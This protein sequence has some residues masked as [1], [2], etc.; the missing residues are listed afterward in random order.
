MNTDRRTA[1]AALTAAGLLWGTTVPLSKVA[2]EWLPPGWLALVR[3][4]VAAA[5]LLGVARF[6]VRAACRP[7]VLATGA[8]GYGGTVLVQNLAIT[9]TSVSHAAL[10]IGA[11]P[12]MVA[13]IAAVWHRSVAR[14]AAW[15]GFAVSLA[16][17][18]LIAGGGG[19]G[20][21]LGGDGLVLL[22]VL[23]SAGFTVSQ[24]RLLRGQDP[25]AVTA[26]Q[27]A[28]AA[29]V[30]LPVAL[31]SGGVSAAPTRARCWPPRGWRWAAPC[32]PSP[33]SPSGSARCP[34]RWPGRSSTWSPWSGR[35]PASR[36]SATRS[37]PPSS[38]VVRPSW[39]GSA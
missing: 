28:A 11:A 10:L 23:L 14:P 17:V 29:L 6:R 2:L 1:V 4:T 30:A 34:L 33:C 32:C 20:A 27:F 38:W 7:A 12:V 15:A 35:W 19:G 16:G 24:A 5:V 36:S 25:V 26:V 8:L 31:V 9:R 21:T 39:A 22:S 13:I 37:G 3:F 18:G